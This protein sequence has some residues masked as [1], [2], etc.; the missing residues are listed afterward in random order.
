MPVFD[1]PIFTKVAYIPLCCFEDHK[2]I[3]IKN[4]DENMF[5]QTNQQ[6]PSS[7]NG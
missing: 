1:Q 3:K 4:K 2:K 7:Q 5:N 6:I